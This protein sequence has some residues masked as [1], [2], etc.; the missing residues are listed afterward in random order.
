MTTTI[1]FQAFVLFLYVALVLALIVGWCAIKNLRRKVQQ[2]YDYAD[3]AMSY[4][5]LL[6]READRL[7]FQQR[8][9]TKAVGPVHQTRSGHLIRLADMTTPHLVNLWET[10]DSGPKKDDVERELKWRARNEVEHDRAE[11]CN[12]RL[13][14]VMSRGLYDKWCDWKNAAFRTRG[15]DCQRQAERRLKKLKKENQK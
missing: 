11:A 8:C 12:Y 2:A 10:L 6:D 15:D 7:G 14:G 13:E 1:I 4:A 9:L 3:R 5:K